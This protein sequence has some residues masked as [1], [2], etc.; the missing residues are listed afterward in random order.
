MY[1]SNLAHNYLF[2]SMVTIQ[3]RPTRAGE[4]GQQ[5]ESV[6]LF[7]RPHSLHPPVSRSQPSHSLINSST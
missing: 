6:G 7:S 2:I 3:V 5:N 4:K 1:K